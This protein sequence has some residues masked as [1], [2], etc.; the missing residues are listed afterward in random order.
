MAATGRRVIGLTHW[1]V[2]ASKTGA[3]VG[4]GAGAALTGW[5]VIGLTHW[6]V[7]A[8]KTGAKV[9][10]GA[11][12]ALTGWRVIGLT[13]WPVAASKTGANWLASGLVGF[14]NGE[15]GATDGQANGWGRPRVHPGSA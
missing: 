5:R 10:V 11:G 12:A 8:S 3:K 13:H 14:T 9:G 7:A 4:V 15:T 6:P 1:P 2:A